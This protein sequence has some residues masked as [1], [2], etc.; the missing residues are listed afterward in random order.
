MIFP[1]SESETDDLIGLL[2]QEGLPTADVPGDVRLYGLKAGEGVHAYGGLE[3]RGGSALLRS[4]LVPAADRGQ[5]HGKKLVRE[6][7]EEA[8]SLGLSEIWL[9]TETAA[10]FFS[11]LGFIHRSREEAPTAIQSTEEFS[12]LCPDSAICMSFRLAAPP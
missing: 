10:S 9:L 5:G 6:L 12:A 1:L 8:R 7:N 11:A 4:I 2:A 3:V